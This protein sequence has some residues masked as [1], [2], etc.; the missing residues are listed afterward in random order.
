MPES[1][2]VVQYTASYLKQNMCSVFVKCKLKGQLAFRSLKHILP[3]N[4]S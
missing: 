1:F 2:S 3:P 4:R